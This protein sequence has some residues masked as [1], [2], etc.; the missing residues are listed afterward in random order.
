MKFWK[1]IYFIK[2]KAYKM[3]LFVTTWD[4]NKFISNSQQRLSGKHVL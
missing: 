1:Q 2:K 4:Q 3:T